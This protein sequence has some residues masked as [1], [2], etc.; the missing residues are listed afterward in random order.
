MASHNEPLK[1]FL[2][3]GGFPERGTGR[4]GAVAFAELT[5]SLSGASCHYFPNGPSFHHQSCPRL[6]TTP[7]EL[8]S[9]H[10][11]DQASSS[12]PR[13]RRS[14]RL[15]LI[16]WRY[17]GPAEAVPWTRED[18]HRS[19][20]SAILSRRSHQAPCWSAGRNQVPTCDGEDKP[21]KASAGYGAW[22]TSRAES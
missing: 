11:R 8:L 15:G 14:F 12:F 4:P 2:S 10:E 21:P 16:D 13:L 19:M 5:S 1:V 9:L 6:V 7:E 3:G 18:F 17:H 22:P 20:L